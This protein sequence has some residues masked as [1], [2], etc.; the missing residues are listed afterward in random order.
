MILDKENYYL[1]K[2]NFFCQKSAFKQVFV[3]K[4][5]RFRENLRK[6]LHISTPQ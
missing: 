5:E 6:T 3:E 1:C 4:E 2:T